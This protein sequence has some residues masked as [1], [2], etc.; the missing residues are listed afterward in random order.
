MKQFERV[1]SR[2][3][4]DGGGLVGVPR[5]KAEKKEEGSS[6]ATEPSAPE[7]CLVEGPWG[8]SISFLRRG[9]WISC[10]TAAQHNQNPFT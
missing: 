6:S 10:S 4:G 2:G 8:L 1:V 9:L 7:V 3:W 5:T